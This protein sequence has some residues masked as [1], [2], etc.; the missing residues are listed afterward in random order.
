M[1]LNARLAKWGTYY[2]LYHLDLITK[3]SLCT[4]IGYF[5]LTSIFFSTA[6]AATTTVQ[7]IVLRSLQLFS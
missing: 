1:I 6:Y 4:L 5:P 2:R 3:H 7:D